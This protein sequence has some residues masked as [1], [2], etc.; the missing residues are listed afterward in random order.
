MG[1][2]AIP[3]HL[4]LVDPP[5]RAWPDSTRPMPA[6]SHQR[7]RQLA[8]ERAVVRAAVTYAAS[9]AGGMPA[10]DRPLR[11][12]CGRRRSGADAGAR[13]AAPA[14]TSLLSRP[15]AGALGS[16]ATDGT[17][18]GDLCVDADRAVARGSS[19]TV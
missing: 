1:G 3:F 11:S 16:A 17:D 10:T 6:S 2:R 12:T 5:D 15:A 14:K 4:V 9:A 18:A 8:S 19:A 7:R 13:R